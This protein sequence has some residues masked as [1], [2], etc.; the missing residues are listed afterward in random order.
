[1]H[2][3]LM[4]FAPLGTSL[5]DVLAKYSENAEPDDGSG[6]EF[7]YYSTDDFDCEPGNSLE[8]L[9]QNY[10][11]KHGKEMDPEE[12]NASNADGYYDWYQVGGRW[13]GFFKAVA[14]PSK[15]AKLGEKSWTN[16]GLVTESNRIDYGLVS[17]VDWLGMSKELLDKVTPAV[18]AVWKAMEDLPL[19]DPEKN[20]SEQPRP[21]AL[22]KLREESEI[23]RNAYGTI[24]RN[25]GSLLNLPLEEALEKIAMSAFGTYSMLHNDEWTSQYE[26][27]VEE[28][29]AS[30]VKSLY[31]KGQE[32]E[33]MV[34]LVD[35]H[36]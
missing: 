7:F 19:I 14:S 34:Y 25:Q 13:A 28:K 18:E 22:H 30:T 8:E 6:A 27:E 15:Y 24:T 35:Y 1:M 16:S 33:Y 31:E 17:D 36:S 10:R 4:V 12:F 3:T 32:H 5:D 23:V 2:A 26:F 29:I 9:M 11:I 20:V 21:M